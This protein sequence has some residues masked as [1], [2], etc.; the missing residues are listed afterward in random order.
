[1]PKRKR[2]GCATI[3]SYLDPSAGQT[4]GL[5]SHTLVRGVRKSPGLKRWRQLSRFRL[6]I[7]THHPAKSTCCLPMPQTQ[8]QTDRASPTTP[9]FHSGYTPSCR[10]FRRACS[11]GCPAFQSGPAPPSYCPTSLTVVSL[12]LCPD[13]YNARYSYAR[14]PCSIGQPA[15]TPEADLVSVLHQTLKPRPRRRYKS[16]CESE[17]IVG[18]RK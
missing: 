3:Y 6:S 11:L 14:L 17:T 2:C 1:M 12:A 16:T 5:Q 8:T 18:G 10:D 15:Q 9:M 4:L 7:S 13:R